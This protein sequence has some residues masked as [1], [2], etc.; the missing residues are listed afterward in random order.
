MLTVDLP[1]PG[2]RYGDV[3]SGFRGLSGLA[4]WLYQARG[5]SRYIA[6]SDRIGSGGWALSCSNITH[7]RYR[8]PFWCHAGAFHAR[9]KAPINCVRRAW[10]GHPCSARTIQ[11]RHRGARRQCRCGIAAARRARA[12]SSMSM[13]NDQLRNPSS[14]GAGRIRAVRCI[15]WRPTGRAFAVVPT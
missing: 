6:I 1:V 7:P 13:T 8:V 5:S 10:C 11:C 15:G 12:V 2:A 9:S 3:R 14:G 4:A